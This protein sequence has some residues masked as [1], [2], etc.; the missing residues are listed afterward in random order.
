[1]AGLTPGPFGYEVL[2]QGAAAHESS[3][4][5]AARWWAQNR[6]R[7]FRAALA[8][9]AAAAGLAGF[10]GYEVGVGHRTDPAPAVAAATDAAA[11]DFCAE[12][13][14]A[15]IATMQGQPPHNGLYGRVVAAAPE[16]IRA[17]AVLA[18]SGIL[19][20]AGA[21]AAGTR[22]AQAADYRVA[23]YCLPFRSP[24]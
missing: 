20:Q 3:R 22:A 24:G 1:V 23:I 17:Q 19:G 13:T 18:L 21:T 2:E 10:V 14:A 16:A 4:W 5:S 11:K 6:P 12:F 7:N 8:L 15:V 9:V